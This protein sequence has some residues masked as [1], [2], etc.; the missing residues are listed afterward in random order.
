[1]AKQLE[2]EAS[3]L[4]SAKKLQKKEA[5]IKKRD[6]LETLKVEEAALKAKLKEER[7]GLGGG[8]DDSELLTVSFSLTRRLPRRGMRLNKLLLN[9]SERRL[10]RPKTL[11]S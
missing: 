7:K 3:A 8:S 2:E 1:M 4:K 10:E 11:L 9:W 6:A 5:E